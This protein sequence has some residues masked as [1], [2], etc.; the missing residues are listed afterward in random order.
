MAIFNC[1]VSSPEGNE[2][3]K[4]YVK[5]NF[6]GILKGNAMVAMMLKR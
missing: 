6:M 4:C 5:V 2:T 1:Y 3:T